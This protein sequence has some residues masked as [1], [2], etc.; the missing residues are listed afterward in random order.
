MYTVKK[1]TFRN[2]FNVLK[3]SKIL[4][5]C[6]KDMAEKYDLH[7]WDNSKFKT[8]VIVG[9]C[10]LKNRIYLVFDEKNALATFQVR[11]CGDLLHF[12]KLAVSPEASGKGIG[13][14]CLEYMEKMGKESGCRR[15]GMEVY[16]P[17]Q[18]A[19]DFY[20][21]RGYKI[22]GETNTLKYTE[23]KMEKEVIL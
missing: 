16:S 7:H 13:S 4:Y 19:I 21:N 11:K 2:I 6:G 20:I 12:E 5:L 15:I 17:S 10:V 9:L 22:I 14:F 23:I 3:V 18:H 8:L 1:I